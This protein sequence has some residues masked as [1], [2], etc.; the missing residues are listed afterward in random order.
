MSQEQ[1]LYRIVAGERYF[2]LRG[3]KKLRNMLDFM[4]ERAERRKEKLRRQIR[5]EGG[6]L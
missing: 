5:K 3:M 4:I 6:E 2:T 1:D